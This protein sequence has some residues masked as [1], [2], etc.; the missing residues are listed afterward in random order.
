MGLVTMQLFSS[1]LPVY[2]A[3]PASNDPP[4]KH[5]KS[6]S[7]SDDAVPSIVMLPQPLNRTKSRPSS[8]YSIISLSDKNLYGRRLVPFH[9]MNECLPYD[10]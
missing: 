10:L 6:Q 9:Q 8:R 2:S 3:P 7:V 4:H 5:M 1:E